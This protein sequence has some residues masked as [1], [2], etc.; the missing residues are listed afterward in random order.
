MTRPSIRIHNQSTNE[1]VD[2]EMNDEE[3]AEYL[4]ALEENNIFQQQVEENKTKRLD[5]FERL[6]ITEEEA[7]QL[8]VNQISIDTINKNAE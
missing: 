4:S 8:F 2:R 3:Y 6:G 5:L 1:I 7:N